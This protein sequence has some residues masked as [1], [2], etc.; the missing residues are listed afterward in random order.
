MFKKAFT[1]VSLCVVG[2][3]LVGCKHE[4]KSNDIITT[5]APKPKVPK[6][7]V[8]LEGFTYRKTINWLGAAYKITIKRAAD[9]SLDVVTDEDGRRYYDNRISLLITRED[10]SEFYSRTF[11]KEDFHSITPEKY[12]KEGVLLGFM[13]DKI[14]LNK[15][16]FGASVGSPNPLSD[17]Y[18][19]LEVVLDNLGGIKITE[20]SDFV[21]GSDNDKINK[22]D[23]LSEAEEYDGV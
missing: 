15:L 10:G 13:F 11:T 9:K 8:A 20:S 3:A 7:P 23:S 18:V 2:A 5:I 17:E 1:V 14:D 12:H 19:P 21:T 4:K 22:V 6:G 16:H